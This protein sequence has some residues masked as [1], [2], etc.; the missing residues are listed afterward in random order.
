[1]NEIDKPQGLWCEHACDA[2]CGI[3]QK[4][5]EVCK[6]F[7]CAWLQPTGHML[8]AEEERPDKIGFCVVVNRSEWEGVE[9]VWF[10]AHFHPR[11]IKRRGRKVLDRIA[12]IKTVLI[13]QGRGRWIHA[14]V[15]VAERSGFAQR[16]VAEAIKRMEAGN[17]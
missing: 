16:V 10:A 17:E 2:G 6:V 7:E 14:H 11:G 13:C 15:G 1:M 9:E 8:L 5:P 12:A 4:R 3:Y